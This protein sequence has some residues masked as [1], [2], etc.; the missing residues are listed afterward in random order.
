MKQDQIDR[1]MGDDGEDHS[2]GFVECSHQ[3]NND[4][5]IDSIET[6]PPV[7]RIEISVDGDKNNCRTPRLQ[8][9]LNS[10]SEQYLLAKARTKGDEDHIC[11]TQV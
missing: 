6:Q 7:H 11:K 8:I 1:K 3:P 9:V 2:P 4:G 5:H 10:T